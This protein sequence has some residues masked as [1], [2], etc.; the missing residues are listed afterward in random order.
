MAAPNPYDPRLLGYL[1][2]TNHSRM[3]TALPVP[4][5]IARSDFCPNHP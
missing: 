5:Q 3:D 2:P 1:Q 4:V